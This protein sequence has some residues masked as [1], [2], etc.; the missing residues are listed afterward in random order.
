MVSLGAL[1]N[2]LKACS[3]TT[4]TTP[5]LTPYLFLAMRVK[6]LP[7]S[8]FLMTGLVHIRLNPPGYQPECFTTCFGR[9]VG[10]WR[11]EPI[12]SFR[13]MGPTESAKMGL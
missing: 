9:G 11:L 3:V 1:S 5:T 7:P 8:P 2:P 10:A 4:S 12:G 6:N 13:S